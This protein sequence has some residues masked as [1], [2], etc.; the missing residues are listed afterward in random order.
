MVVGE[1]EDVL[2]EKNSQDMNKRTIIEG[3]ENSGST[4]KLRSGLTLK[5]IEK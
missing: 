5:P 4:I 3:K 2:V 1:F